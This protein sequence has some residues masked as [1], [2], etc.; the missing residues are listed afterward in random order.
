MIVLC[1]CM[2]RQKHVAEKVK[3][4]YRHVNL[5]FGPQELWRFPELYLK[6]KERPKKIVCSLDE[7]TPWRRNCR[8]RETE[9]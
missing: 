9:A 3:K 5:I 2:A 6:A 4:S 7:L 8:G 1:G